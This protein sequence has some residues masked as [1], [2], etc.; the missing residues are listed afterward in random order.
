MLVQIIVIIELKYLLIHLQKSK[1]RGVQQ[2]IQNTL[3]ST[4]NITVRNNA[5]I[6]LKT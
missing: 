5:K 3:N 4:R 2:D 6:M 1:Q